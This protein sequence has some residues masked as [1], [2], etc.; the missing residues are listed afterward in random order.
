LYSWKVDAKG[1][2][3]DVKQTKLALVWRDIS[4]STDLYLYA[5]KLYKGGDDITSLVTITDE[6]GNNLKTATASSGANKNS[7]NVIIY[8]A[9]EDTTA[10]DT[11]STYLLRATASGFT[12][13]AN[14]SND[15]GVSINMPTDTTVNGA[16]IKYLTNHATLDYIQLG[17]SAEA[18]TEDANLIWSDN[19][20]LSHDATAS[21][22]DNGTA[23]SSGDWANGYLVKDLPLSTNTFVGP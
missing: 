6:D 11:S 22:D 18:S 12:S 14:V 5:F 4:G 20:D 3:V 8:W 16:T 1:G 2:Q 17:T 19:S 23:S 9:T 21:E 13:A 15:D 10:K 7:A